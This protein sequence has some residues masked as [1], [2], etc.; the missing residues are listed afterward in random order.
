MLKYS[1]EVIPSQTLQ[2]NTMKVCLYMFET[3]IWKRLVLSRK[4]FSSYVKII[5]ADFFLP[6]PNRKILTNFKVLFCKIWNIST[7][8]F[9]SQCLGWALGTC[10]NPKD[11][12]VHLVQPC[13]MPWP[14][15][16]GWG[17]FA[18]WKSLYC[19]SALGNQCL[20]PHW[21]FST[22]RYE[23]QNWKKR[24]FGGILQ[25]MRKDKR[26]DDINAFHCVVGY[27]KYF[28]AHFLPFCLSLIFLH[29]FN[30]FSHLYFKGYNLQNFSFAVSDSSWN[31]RCLFWL[32][33]KTKANFQQ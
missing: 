2:L 3:T 21:L 23:V 9:L 16:W 32:C 6:F 17:Y 8:S 19:P 14:L 30:G 5:Q 4:Q 18:I 1:S 24:A 13:K 22:G 15:C 33:T 29:G 10:E 12:S 26:V 20:H 31:F 25:G 7:P 11:L 27:W 28:Q